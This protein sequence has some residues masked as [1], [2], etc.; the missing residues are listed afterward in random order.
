MSPSV[1]T[2]AASD[3]SGIAVAFGFDALTFFVSALTLWFI[4]TKKRVID[5]TTE[6]ESILS[7]MKEGLTYVAASPTLRSVF[8]L[9]I[10]ANV[11]INAPLVIGIPVLA[12][13]RLP[14]G[15]LLLALLCQHSEG[16]HFSGW[17]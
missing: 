9:I 12:D 1:D 2:N 3:L 17:G 14:A 15:R 5:E 11:L 8:T 6:S 7:S 4:K 16:A 13:V 10:F